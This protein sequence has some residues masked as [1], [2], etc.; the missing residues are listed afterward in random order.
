MMSS[1]MSSQIGLFLFAIL[2]SSLFSEIT[3]AQVNPYNCWMGGTTKVFTPYFHPVPGDGTEAKCISVLQECEDLCQ[4]QG[5]TKVWDICSYIEST[6]NYACT[7]CCGD[8][9]FRPP[10]LPPSRRDPRD[11]CQLNE[12]SLSTQ[13]RSCPAPACAN[14]P[15]RCASIGATITYRRCNLNTGFC[16]CCCSTFNSGLPS[17]TR[18]RSLGS[19]LVDAAQ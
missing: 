10:P 18:I 12:I 1:S 17:S 2:A 7:A 19:S 5:R 14:C 8:A 9:S 15:G 16:S 3:Y 6:Q 13:V 11:E 4:A